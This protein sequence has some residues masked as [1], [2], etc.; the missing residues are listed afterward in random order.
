M[1]LF[2]PGASDDLVIGILIGIPLGV[3]LD[4]F[5]L[6]PVVRLWA[7]IQRGWDGT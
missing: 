4:S 6:R 7:R 5:V 1:M 3:V 2:G